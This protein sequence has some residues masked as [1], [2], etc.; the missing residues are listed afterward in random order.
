ML[1]VMLVRSKENR[2]TNLVMVLEDSGS[3][4]WRLL[5]ECLKFCSRELAIQSLAVF[6]GQGGGA[7]PKANW[8]TMSRNKAQV[9]L[10]SKPDHI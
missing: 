3:E 5:Q 6:G 7:Y 2:P 4:L 8:N 9:R 1:G 10:D